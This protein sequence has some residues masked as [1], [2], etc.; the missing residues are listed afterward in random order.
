[1]RRLPLSSPL[2]LVYD[3]HD[4]KLRKE[5]QKYSGGEAG[6]WSGRAEVGNHLKISLFASVKLPEW[7]VAA[8]EIGGRSIQM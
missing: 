2:L 1:M 5:M 6:S 8:R 7:F 4:A 3:K